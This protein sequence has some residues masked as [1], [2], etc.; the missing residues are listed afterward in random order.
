MEKVCYS[1]GILTKCCLAQKPLVRSTFHVSLSF[2]EA[3]CGVTG[4]DSGNPSE[5]P[6]LPG[7]WSGSWRRFLGLGRPIRSGQ[8]GSEGSENCH[9]LFATFWIKVSMEEK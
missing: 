4:L 7:G 3:D 9:N 1:P 5:L 8:G 2:P 6:W